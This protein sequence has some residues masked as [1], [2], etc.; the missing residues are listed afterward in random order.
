MA[1]SLASCDCCGSTD[2]H[3]REHETALLAL[4]EPFTVVRC[5]RCGL[6][7]LDPQPD[8]GDFV[9]LYGESYFTGEEQ[10][11][12]H[13]LAKQT[14]FGQQLDL[15]EPY[16]QTGRRLLEIG[17]AMGH[18]LAQ[19]EQRGFRAIGVEVSRWAAASALRVFRTP[20][21]V[22]NIEQLA[23]PCGAFDVV[24]LSHV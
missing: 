14:D 20:V 3:V 13:I 24:V 2:W 21:I 22:G 4:P 10:Y 19:A 6:R 7:F 12:D 1:T 15:L 17:C 5:R 18:F 11:A 8:E 16:A 23:F 9:D